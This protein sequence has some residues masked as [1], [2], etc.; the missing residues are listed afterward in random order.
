MQFQ[1][2]F[3]GRSRGTKGGRGL[4]GEK[5]QVHANEGVKTMGG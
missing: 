3:I 2:G 4:H 5:E 1:K